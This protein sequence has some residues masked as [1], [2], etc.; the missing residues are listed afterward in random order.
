MGGDVRAALQD[1]FRQVFNR[2]DLVITEK[3][4]ADDVKGWDS[5]KHIELIVSV[6]SKFGVKFKTAEVTKLND[7]GDLIQM[8]V[9]RMAPE[10]GTR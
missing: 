7:V 8:L 3:T 10:V 6:E 5:L 2:P 9:E 4:T 1:V